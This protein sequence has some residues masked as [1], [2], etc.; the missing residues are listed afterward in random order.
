[1]RLDKLATIYSAC[2]PSKSQELET[3]EYLKGM[4]AVLVLL[5]K[6]PSHSRLCALHKGK[7]LKLD[8]LNTS[9]FSVATQLQFSDML[10][11]QDVDLI[12]LAYT[13]LNHTTTETKAHVHT[14]LQWISNSDIE[15]LNNFFQVKCD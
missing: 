4:I 9:S 1:M 2:H 12:Q 3:N 10:I 14:A 15:R 5:H 11:R 8:E 7:K 13:E 6:E